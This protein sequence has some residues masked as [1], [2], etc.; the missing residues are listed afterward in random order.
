V[1]ADLT[2]DPDRLATLASQL[3]A[4]T[5]NLKSDRDLKGYDVEDVSHQKVAD[6]IDDFVNDWDDKRNKLTEKVESIGQMAEK[7][8][9]EFTKVDLDLAAALTE[10]TE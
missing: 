4:I 5:Q 8:H 6:A 1:T 7:S 9:D 3:G 10:K 2:Y